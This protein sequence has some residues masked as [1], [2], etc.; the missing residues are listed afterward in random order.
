MGILKGLHGST[1]FWGLTHRGSH[2]IVHESV[3]EGRPDQPRQRVTQVSQETQ[4]ERNLPNHQ[5]VS[6]TWESD[7]HTVR[8]L[9]LVWCNWS[10]SGRSININTRGT[11]ERIRSCQTIFM[12]ES[13][14]KAKLSLANMFTISNGGKAMT[15]NR[16]QQ[17]S[18]AHERSG[19]LRLDKD[20]LGRS[21]VK[22]R[23]PKSTDQGVIKTGKASPQQLAFAA[24]LK[25]GMTAEEARKEAGLPALR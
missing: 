13:E 10:L 19:Y 7:E 24:Y 21:N 6:P 8:W 17:R 12:P 20:S 25:S 5:R 23:G 1:G 9:P 22:K 14:V 2:G 3:G 11:G 15:Y 16:D 4:R 18:V